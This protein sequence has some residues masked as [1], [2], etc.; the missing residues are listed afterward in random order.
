MARSVIV[1]ASGWLGKS[2]LHAHLDLVENEQP[3]ILVSR[4]ENLIEVSGSS[5]M[6]SPRFPGY[7][8]GHWSDYIHCAFATRERFFSLGLSA[9]VSENK[10]IINEART[11]VLEGKPD[12][13]VIVSSGA[14]TKLPLA[15]QHDRS[16]ETYAALKRLELETLREAARMVGAKFIEGRLFSATGIY[17]KDPKLFAIGNL[18]TQ[19]L[20][21]SRILI[22]SPIPTYRRYCDSV[23]FMKVLLHK[24]ELPDVTKVD[25]GGAIVELGELALEVASTLGVDCEIVRG[26]FTG[27][28]FDD[29]FSRSWQFERG[30]YNLG[31][32][33]LS[34]RAQILNVNRR[35]ASLAKNKHS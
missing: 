19:A 27:N 21:G 7:T 31:E 11:D 30:L 4:T 5:F 2:A 14:V 32:A 10:R 24:A 20:T 33:P 17:M 15:E 26:P 18:V 9:Y 12:R 22:S 29:Y 1:G 34:L 16:Y 6:T 23:Q 35:L 3:P 25:S 8:D 28:D 13:V